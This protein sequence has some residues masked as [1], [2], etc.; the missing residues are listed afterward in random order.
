MVPFLVRVAQISFAHSSS[1]GGEAVVNGVT[2]VSLPVN[3]INGGLYLHRPQL[4]GCSRPSGRGFSYC[5]NEPIHQS[6]VCRWAASE[7]L[8]CCTDFGAW[9]IFYVSFTPFTSCSYCHCTHLC[10]GFLISEKD[11]FWGIK[12]SFCA[13]WKKPGLIAFK[14]QM[15]IVLVDV[16]IGSIFYVWSI[17][18]GGYLPKQLG[19]SDW[20]LKRL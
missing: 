18:I 4:W 14:Q 6:F 16:S 11:S 20:M 9:L 10:C 3:T 5:T 8:M 2:S 13:Q 7:Q 12:Y 17:F 19:L 1:R 15:L